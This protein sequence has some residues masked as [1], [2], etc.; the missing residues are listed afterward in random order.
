MEKRY[1][2][3]ELGFKSASLNRAF[4]AFYDD[5]DLEKIALSKTGKFEYLIID[6]L[7]RQQYSSGKRVWEKID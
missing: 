4:V 1:L 6:I 5:C 7:L 3:V 2:I